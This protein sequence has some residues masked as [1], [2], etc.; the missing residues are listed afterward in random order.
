MTLKQPWIQQAGGADPAISYSALDIRAL[1]DALFSNEGVIGRSSLAVSQRG[2][3]ANF[4]VD[5]AAGFAVIDGD[6]TPLQG[7]YVVQNTATYNLPMPSP[8]VSGS[9]I[10]RVIARVRDKLHDGTQTTYDW[11]LEYLEDVG[12]GLIAQP[13]S[14]ITLA[15]VTLTAGDT[16]ITASNI[17][18][19]R[20]DAQGIPTVPYTA[21]SSAARPNQALTTERIW[22][23][24]KSYFEVWN[25]SSWQVDG[26]ILSLYKFS[27]TSRASTTVLADDPDLT[28]SVAAGVYYELT[29]Q[30]VYSTRS[31]TDFQFDLVG[32]TAATFDGKFSAQLPANTGISG[33]VPH[34][35]EQLGTTYTFGGA[36]AENTTYMVVGMSGTLYSGDGGTFK[37]RWSQ[38]ASNVTATI[39][40]GKSFITLRPVR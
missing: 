14:S 22:R 24:D 5:I 10:H 34:D 40:R 33:V 26:P 18:D 31:D 3:G 9:R 17:F 4:S 37:V 2:A 35:R 1:T 28:I 15:L 21:A 16:S 6:D 30:L 13:A 38:S 19:L 29:G 36:A 11:V 7:T 39:L 20:V 12:G 27:D 32:P 25:G 8:P 23:S